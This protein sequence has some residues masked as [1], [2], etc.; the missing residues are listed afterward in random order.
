MEG[1]GGTEKMERNERG[2]LAGLP[3]DWDMRSDAKAV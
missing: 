3:Y 2:T 1:C